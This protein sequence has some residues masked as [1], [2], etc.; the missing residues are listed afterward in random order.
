MLNPAVNETDEQ[1]P[2]TPLTG[3]NPVV[4]TAVLV[5]IG[6]LSLCL[7]ALIASQA[8]GIGRLAEQALR[9]LATR[10]SQV[11]PL[12]PVTESSDEP[13]DSSLPVAGEP[14]IMP[15]PSV[16]LQIIGDAAALFTSDDY[17]A[18]ALRQDAQGTLRFE[19]R[20][21]P[22]G[23][24]RRCQIIESSGVAS[25]DSVS[26]RIAMA[27]LRFNPARDSTNQPIWSIYSRRVRWVLPK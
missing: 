20:V 27:R 7:L 19:V 26:C 4:T 12:P 8:V 3:Q 6:V 22:T 17:P 1:A 14:E 9:S 2:K 5:L 11:S 23:R 24:P 21:D 10:P 25:L 15:T 16:Q 18:E 13:A